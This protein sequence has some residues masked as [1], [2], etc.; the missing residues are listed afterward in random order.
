MTLTRE[1]SVKVV[2]ST[3]GINQYSKQAVSACLASHSH[4]YT[5]TSQLQ[6]NMALQ[7]YRLHD[8][9]LHKAQGEVVLVQT[10]HGSVTLGTQQQR[11]SVCGGSPYHAHH[12]VALSSIYIGCEW[13]LT[14]DS[15]AHAAQPCAQLCL[16]Q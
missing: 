15:S 4:T 10:S 16:P 14:Q 8:Q 6:P 5:H 12:P 13:G 11:V 3:N 1:M 2:S 9:W 7:L